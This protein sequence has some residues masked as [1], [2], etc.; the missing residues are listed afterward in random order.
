MRGAG[1]TARRR[2]GAALACVCVCV[3]IEVH[4]DDSRADRLDALISHNRGRIFEC[5]SVQHVRS[6]LMAA[7]ASRVTGD[8]SALRGRALRLAEHSVVVTPGG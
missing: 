5:E 2:D 8:T 3:A 4:V 6:M 7:A 1:S